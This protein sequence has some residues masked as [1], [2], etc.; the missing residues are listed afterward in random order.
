MNF[1]S[2]LEFVFDSH[3][4]STRTSRDPKQHINNLVELVGSTMCRLFVETSPEFSIP[5]NSCGCF[6]HLG[7]N[8]IMK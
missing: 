4:L 3:L 7:K 1:N 5:W 6:R 8:G 2:L